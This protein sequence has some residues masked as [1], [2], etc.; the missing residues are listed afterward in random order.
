M[1]TKVDESRPQ[2][3][4][5]FQFSRVAHAQKQSAIEIYIQW[6]IFD[7][8]YALLSKKSITNDFVSCD[9]ICLIP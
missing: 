8:V 4:V 6:N 3:Y 9:M 7:P 1:V 2:P 5:P